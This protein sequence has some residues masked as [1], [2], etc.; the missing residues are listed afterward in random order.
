M[1]TSLIIAAVLVS[2]TPQMRIDQVYGQIESNRIPRTAATIG[3]PYTAPAQYY[4]P[5]SSYS[6][7]YY[8]PY[9]Y[10]SYSSPYYSLYY[11]PYSHYYR[12]YLYNYHHRY[13]NW[14]WRYW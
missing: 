12:P 4:P 14:Y 13:Y 9:S 6:P 7:Y 10:S 3:I 2:Q 11:S 1:F 5:Y 8:S